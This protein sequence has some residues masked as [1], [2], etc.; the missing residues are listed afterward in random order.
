MPNFLSQILQGGV[1][2][3]LQ[4]HSHAGVMQSAGA[5]PASPAT[6]DLIFRTDLGAVCQWDGTRWLGPPQLVTP[7][8]QRA[9]GPGWTTAGGT[10]VVTL[11]ACVI[12]GEIA[13][14]YVQTTNNASNYWTLNF[15]NEALT[16]FW[17]V[18]TAAQSVGTATKY[19]GSTVQ[20]VSSIQQVFF[21]IAKTGSPG[22]FYAYP[23]L[24]IRRIYT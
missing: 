24:N 4:G 11:P 5:F 10:Y 1:A 15:I 17:T 3:S 19:T 7:Q 23:L 9:A 8:L 21:D 20:V 13:T 6:N 22:A 16:T 14:L 12:T 18:N 2:V